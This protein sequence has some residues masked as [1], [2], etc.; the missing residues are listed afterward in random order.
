MVVVRHL[1][2]FIVWWLGEEPSTKR[3]LETFERALVQVWAFGEPVA[4]PPTG[5][6]LSFEW[7]DRLADS[8]M[9]IDEIQ[10]GAGRPN[11]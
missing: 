9:S 3:L 8:L 10:A 4:W 5:G 1:A 6:R 11:E 7:L 2:A